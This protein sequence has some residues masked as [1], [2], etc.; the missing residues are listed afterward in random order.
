MLVYS[1]F[2]LKAGTTENPESEKR[3]KPREISPGFFIEMVG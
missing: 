3:K 1:S 2:Y